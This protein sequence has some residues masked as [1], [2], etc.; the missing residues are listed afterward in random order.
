MTTFKWG[1]EQFVNIG[2][3]VGDQGDPSV[4]ALADGGYVVAWEDFGTNVNG[5]VHFQRYDAMGEAVGDNQ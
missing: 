5:E 2:A 4:A 3:T 1:G